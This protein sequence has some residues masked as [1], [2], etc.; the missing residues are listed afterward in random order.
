MSHKPAAAPKKSV[1]SEDDRDKM[2]ERLYVLS[3][4]TRTKRI[5][6][7][8][9]G[10]DAVYKKLHPK[11]RLGDLSE[12]EEKAVQHLYQQSIER[13]AHTLKKLEDKFVP[14]PAAAKVL[15]PEEIDGMADR[16][17]SQTKLHHEQ[18]M[19]RLEVKYYG[20]KG[21]GQRKLSKAEMDE[22]VARQY[23][24]ARDKKKENY[25]KL[26]EKYLFHPPKKQISPEEIAEMATRLSTKEQR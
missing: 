16:L 6:E 20:K 8:N 3:N 12:R 7:F 4:K 13:K 11:P 9:D 22:S 24:G 18:M 10:V 26:E 19:G 23:T 21:E 1:L 17:H 15:Q 5:S 2:M 25:A 14:K